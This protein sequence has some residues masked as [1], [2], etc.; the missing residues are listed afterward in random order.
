MRNY[1]RRDYEFYLNADTAVGTMEY[2]PVLLLDTDRV[3]AMEKMLKIDDLESRLPG[4]HCGSCGAPSCHAFAEDVVLGRA[5][6]EDCIFKMRERMQYMAG[7]RD[8]D[9]YLPAPFRQR[10]APRG[11]NPEN[12]SRR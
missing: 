4:L 7:E 8:A 9:A 3:T 5:S 1:L 6:Q 2:Q 11:G 12:I 10:P